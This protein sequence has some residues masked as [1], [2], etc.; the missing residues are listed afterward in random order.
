MVHYRWLHFQ[1]DKHPCATY[2][3]VYQGYRVLT[4]PQPFHPQVALLADLRTALAKAFLWAL[5]SSFVPFPRGFKIKAWPSVSSLTHELSLPHSRSKLEAAELLRSDIR[6]LLEVAV[7]SGNQEVRCMPE[8]CAE[9]EQDLLPLF[10]C[11]RP[12]SF[13]TPN[14][15]SL[16]GMVVHLTKRRGISH[17]NYVC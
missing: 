3:A 5:A 8:V 12:A 10:F 2:F 14:A 15:R 17:G 13:P 7:S 11:H 6:T 16:Q 4:D 9:A 1:V